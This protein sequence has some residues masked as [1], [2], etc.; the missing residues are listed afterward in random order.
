M[1]LTLPG[2]TDPRSLA[3]R[4]FFSAILLSALVLVSA[5]TILS[6]I[7]RRSVEAAFDERLKLYLKVLVADV[8]ALTDGKQCRAR[9][10]RRAAIQIPLSLSA[11]TGRSCALIRRSNT[12]SILRTSRSLF[13]QRLPPLVEPGMP[14]SRGDFRDGYRAGRKDAASG[15]SSRKSI[16]ASRIAFSSPSP[17][18]PKRLSRN[19]DG[20]ISVLM[21][22]S[23]LG[24]ALGISAY[25]Q[26]RYGLRPL[27]DLSQSLSQVRNG[28]SERVEGEFPVEVARLRA[29]SISF[30]DVNREIV[31]RA[32]AQVGNLAHASALKTHSPS[33]STRR[34]AIPVRW[35]QDPRAD[36]HHA[37]SGSSISGS[38]SRCSRVLRRSEASRRSSRVLAAF[39]RTF[40]KIYRDRDILFCP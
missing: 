27:R 30:L 9:Q 39:T 13:N 17:G 34:E 29:S 19:G 37:R 22:L 21:L 23:L 18:T 8:A 31:S 33:C 38:R 28:I 40:E 25:V 3:G 4:L 2:P 24:L 35:R 26:V 12:A 10:S 11:G 5:G 14:S 36:R 6:A 1:R 32:R 7:N 15:S 20:L 16:L